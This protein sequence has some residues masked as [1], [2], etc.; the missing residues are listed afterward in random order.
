MS[1]RVFCCNKS[2]DQFCFICGKWARI[3]NRRQITLH[4]RVLYKQYFDMELLHQESCWVPH[5]AC[6]RCVSDLGKWSK[7]NGHL[8]F[9]KPMIWTDPINHEENCYICRTKVVYSKNTENSIEYARVSSV[10]LPV[11]H[12]DGIPIPP[13][14]GHCSAQD[15]CEDND[16]DTETYPPRDNPIYL[17]DTEELHLLSQG[18]LNDLQRDLYLTK[19]MSELLASRLQQWNLLEAGV[20]V[21]ET[22]NRSAYLARYF[23]T[24]DKICYCTDIVELF[25]AMKEPFVGREWRLFIDGSKTSIKAVLLHIGNVKPSIPVTFVSGMK[26]EYSTMRDI[27]TLIQYNRFMFKIVADFKVIAILMGLQS[28]YTKYC[29]YLCLWDSRDYGQ[30]FIRSTWPART[31]YTPEQYNI[32]AEPLV[33]RNKIVVPPLHIKLG[34]MRNFVRAIEK[35]NIEAMEFLE[36]MFP[37]LSRMKIHQGIFVGPQIRKALNSDEFIA[38]LTDD[39]QKAWTSFEAV[40]NGFLGNFKDPNYKKIIDDMLQNY[41]T[42]GARLSLKMHF[43]KSHI[44]FFPENLGAESDEH[45]ERFHQDISDMEDRFNGRYVPNMLGEFCWSLLRDT[46]YMHKR[47]SPRKHF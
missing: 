18:D 12:N 23:A 25:A 41:E 30:H 8:M 15:D 28:G 14:P 11:L 22:R 40:V 4:L 21:T 39:E 32:K 35:T 5:F 38:L 27:L 37:K 7:G 46:K 19:Q 6:L 29:C 24:R 1:S 10:K 36:N 47:R 17:P 34:L 2:P 42:I 45:G 31:D 20:L 43:L 13:S 3:S 9:G 33:P 44:D 16:S 26:E